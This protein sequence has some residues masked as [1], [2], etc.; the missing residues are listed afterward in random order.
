MEKF[1]V[2]IIGAGACGLMAA[3]TLSNAKQKVCLLEAR[4]RIGGRA[5]TINKEGFSKPIEAGAEFIHGNLELT[6]SLLKEAGIKYYETDGEL[7]Q[8]KN[9]DLIKR[10]DFIVHADDLMKKMKL[11]D[12][13][14]SIAAFLKKYFA[15]EK[16][17]EMK[18]SLQQYM[19]GYDA[20]DINFA[21]M[22]ALKDEW[23]KEEDVQFRIKGGYGRLMEFIKNDCE[24][25][26]ATLSCRL[27]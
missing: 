7:W 3:K 17:A 22:L 18:R 4:D 20:A 14:M 19:E 10:E 26:A 11:L 8:L 21:S 24:Q 6:I 16:F 25:R 2:I 5:Y 9:N 12:Q 15:G 1:D 27:L 23:E 13:D